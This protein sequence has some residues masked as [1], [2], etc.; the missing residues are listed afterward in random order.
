MALFTGSLQEAV[1]PHLLKQF[2]QEYPRWFPDKSC[3]THH[4]KF[5]SA[6]ARGE[7]W[8]PLLCSKKL[9]VFDKRT[10]GLF[11]A[12]FVGDGMVA[13]CNKTEQNK[14]SYKWLNKCLNNVTKET[15]LHV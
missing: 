7:A 4:E 12:E 14:T 10:P 9:D 2:Y 11:K 3:A 5:V 13:L 6:R 15:F 8:D 1:K